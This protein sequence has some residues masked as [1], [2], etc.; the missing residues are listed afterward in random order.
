MRMK[1]SSGK[2]EKTFLSDS[3]VFSVE[4]AMRLHS[5]VIVG[6]SMAGMS[7]SEGAYAECHHSHKVYPVNSTYCLSGFEFVCG[8]FG[9]WHKTPA[10][11]K[12]DAA[13]PTTG[14]PAKEDAAKDKPTADS[15][16]PSR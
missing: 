3:V 14:Q 8:D 16:R 12:A 1:S 5:V 11:C 2:I 13:Q 4:G 15:P 7:I 6:M 10:V 9:A